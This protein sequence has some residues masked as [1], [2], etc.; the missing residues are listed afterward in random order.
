M[1]LIVGLPAT[2]IQTRLGQVCA[3]FQ[4]VRNSETEPHSQDEHNS[5]RLET[6]GEHRQVIQDKQENTSR[7]LG[8]F[9]TL[10]NGGS[11]G[12]A[13]AFF[14]IVQ[15]IQYFYR[16]IPRLRCLTSCQSEAKQQR[17]QSVEHRE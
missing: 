6:V 9:D 13:T 15:S 11:H 2:V 12:K 10:S 17:V 3:I 7:K 4:A 14:I 1:S 5:R 16:L 8:T